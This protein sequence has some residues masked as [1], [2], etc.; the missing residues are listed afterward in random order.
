M[1]AARMN[2]LDAKAKAIVASLDQKKKEKAAKAAAAKKQKAEEQRAQPTKA[3]K[4]SPLGECATLH[5]PPT[6]TPL[7]RAR[8][9]TAKQHTNST[10]ALSLHIFYNP[11]Y[12]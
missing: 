10:H 1:K 11:R 2:D 6:H 4:R 7:H 5:A 3:R 9:S 8:P 12:R